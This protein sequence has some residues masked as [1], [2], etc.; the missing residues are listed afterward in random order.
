MLGRLLRVVVSGREE[1]YDDC[2]VTWDHIV[3]DGDRPDYM[4]R[5]R[6]KKKYD[7]DDSSELAIM[8][9]PITR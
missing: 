9:L 4:G 8:I 7:E 5:Y 6:Y 1:G 2:V 3:E